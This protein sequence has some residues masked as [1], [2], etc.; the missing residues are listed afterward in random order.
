MVRHRDL[1]LLRGLSD[2]L[3]GNERAMLPFV[4]NILGILYPQGAKVTCIYPGALGFKVDE[5]A[6]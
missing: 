1:D 3:Q 5:P 6:S 2:A 4:Q